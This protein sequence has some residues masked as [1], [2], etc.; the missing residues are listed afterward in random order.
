MQSV[1][2]IYIP[3][4]PQPDTIVAVFLLKTFGKELF[5][6]VEKAIVK[7][8]ADVSESTLPAGALALDVGGGELDHHKKVPAVTCSELVAMKLGVKEDPA[9]AKL[10]EYSRRD[11]MAGKGTVSSDPLD[12]AFGLSGLVAALNKTRK[13]DAA[14]IVEA[15]LPLI[16]GHYL[17]EVQRTVEL[18]KEFEKKKAEGKVDIFEIRHRDKKL[19]VVIL[20]SDNT[21]MPGFL[22]SQIGG[23]FDVVVQRMASGHTNIL[24]RPTKRVDLRSLALV[25]R[26][27]EANQAGIHMKDDSRYLSQPG[28]ISEVSN[29]YYDTATNSIQN[30]GANPKDTIPTRIDTFAMRKLVEVG[31][32][33]KIWSP[34]AR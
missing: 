13:D 33:E 19:S 14:G 22:R 21:S 3:S 12:K 26:L 23:R 27:E 5:P 17:E 8:S 32:E 20:E 30:G 16:E 29:W 9:I 2:S 11:D 6:G 1:N 25:I 4:R 18:P 15:V 31:L 7:V 28:K 24:T 10:L 34:L